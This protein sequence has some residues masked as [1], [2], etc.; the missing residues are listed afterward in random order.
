VMSIMLNACDSVVSLQD[1]EGSTARLWA[2][3]P[4]MLPIL[5]LCCRKVV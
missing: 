2:T 4:Q 5:L 3:A 1:A